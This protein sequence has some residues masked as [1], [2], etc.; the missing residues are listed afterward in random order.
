MQHQVEVI[1]LMLM[2]WEYSVNISR[3]PYFLFADLLVDS[4]V[5]SFKFFRSCSPHII[6]GK[7]GVCPKRVAAGSIVIGFVQH[8]RIVTGFKGSATEI[9]VFQHQSILLVGVIPGPFITAPW[10]H[11]AIMAQNIRCIKLAPIERLGGL[12]AE[13]FRFNLY[14]KRNNFNIGC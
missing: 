6:P 8:F 2:L 13:F 12:S 11:S 5:V 9:W 10:S 1:V 3:W 4:R 14:K 7:P